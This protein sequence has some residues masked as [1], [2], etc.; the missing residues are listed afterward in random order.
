ML[1]KTIEEKVRT[2]FATGKVHITTIYTII[3]HKVEDMTIS[4][5]KQNE[6]SRIRELYNEIHK[7]LD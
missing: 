1:I 3:D 5:S 4:E 2:N 7:M 6:V